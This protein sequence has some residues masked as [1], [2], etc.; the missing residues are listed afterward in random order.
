MIDSLKYNWPIVAVMLLLSGLIFSMKFCSR[1]TVVLD[2]PKQYIDSLLIEN[3][4]L[5]KAAQDIELKRIEDSVSLTKEINYYKA[6][7]RKERIVYVQTKIGGVLKDQD[8]LTCFT[9]KQVDS[10][11]IISIER[12]YCYEDRA[13][14]IKLNSIKDIQLSN[15][16]Q[17]LSKSLVYSSNLEVRYNSLRKD[18]D[19]QVDKKIRNRKIAIISSAIAILEGF[20]IAIIP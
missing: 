15:S 13:E 17:A 10:V 7:K 9:D 1:G 14:L 18:R 4:I 6:L 3:K 11:G 20:Y 8:T 2:S 12:D 16:S 19:K 5:E